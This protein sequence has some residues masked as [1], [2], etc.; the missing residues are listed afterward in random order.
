VT[1]DQVYRG[2]FVQAVVDVNVP[3]G[4]WRM[5]IRSPGSSWAK[6][7]GLAKSLEGDQALEEAKQKV[8]QMIAWRKTT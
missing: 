3:G 1:K 5:F 8:D 4:P 6:C 2:W 7:M